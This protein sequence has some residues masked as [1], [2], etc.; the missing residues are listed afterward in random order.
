MGYSG[1]YLAL[2]KQNTDVVKPPAL[3]NSFLF[4]ITPRLIALPTVIMWPWC[5][6]QPE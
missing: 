5:M 4:A 6:V 2:I 1:I 3:S